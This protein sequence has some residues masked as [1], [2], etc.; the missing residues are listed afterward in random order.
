MGTE[1]PHSMKPYIRIL[2]G[3]ILLPGFLVDLWFGVIL[4]FPNQI[5][6]DML[7]DL[8][9]NW[10]KWS[11]LALFADML[12]AAVPAF[13]AILA[14]LA[15]IVLGSSYVLIC[16]IGAILRFIFS[17]ELKWQLDD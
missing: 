14:I 9:A 7:E 10:P 13:I 2:I 11:V 5:M 4:I 12:L 1:T 17:G 3:L 6:L 8:T 15:V 16:S